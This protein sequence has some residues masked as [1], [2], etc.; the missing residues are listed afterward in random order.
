MNNFNISTIE[1]ALKAMVKSWTI[2]ERVYNNRPKAAVPAD[3][4][5]VTYIIG[6]VNDNAVF[7]STTVAIDLFAKDLNNEK[8]EVKLGWMYDEFVRLFPARYDVVEGG[9][10]KASFLFDQHP[11]VLGDAPDDYGFHARMIQVKT[12]IKAIR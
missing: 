8:N 6:Q 11:V 4:F 1:G 7:G 9:E 10:V 5:V 2:G 12:I 3:S